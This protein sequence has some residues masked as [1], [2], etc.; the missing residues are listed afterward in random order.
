[1]ELNEQKQREYDLMTAMWHLSFDMSR[2][3]LEEDVCGDDVID[4]LTELAYEFVDEFYDEDRSYLDQI[5]EF[6]QL[7]TKEAIIKRLHK[8]DWWCPNPWRID[9][10]FINHIYCDGTPDGSYIADEPNGAKDNF[11]S[12]SDEADIWYFDEL[13]WVELMDLESIMPLDIDE[14]APLK[15]V[16][17]VCPR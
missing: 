6:E 17:H 13:T 5:D 8:C 12:H 10:K 3:I 2:K 7:Y 4:K 14:S 1:M 9:S 15:W 11:T 16:E